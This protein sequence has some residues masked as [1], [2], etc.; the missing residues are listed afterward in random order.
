MGPKFSEETLQRA[1]DLLTAKEMAGEIDDDR[2]IIWIKAAE[3]ENED[4]EPHRN[5]IR[6][7]AE[8]LTDG[9]SDS[10]VKTLQLAVVRALE[11]YGQRGVPLSDDIATEL[12]AE[13]F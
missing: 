6:V 12:L 11:N 7:R 3:G 9:F 13:F 10:R 8:C 2:T 4:D 1:A 5:F